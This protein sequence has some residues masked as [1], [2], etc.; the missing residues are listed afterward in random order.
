MTN[1]NYFFFKRKLN[2]AISE[3]ASDY[4]TFNDFKRGINN[5]KNNTFFVYSQVDSKSIP[6]ICMNGTDGAK[7]YMNIMFYG[8]GIYTTLSYE[9]CA[10][11]DWSN[12]MVKYAVKK[13]AFNNFLIF[14]IGIKKLLQTKGVLTLH[15]KISDTVKRLFSHDD[16]KMFE[17]YYGKGL[18]ELDK[19]VVSCK[20]SIDSW[21]VEKEFL[22]VA[23]EGEGDISLRPGYK[24][25]SEKRLDVSNVDGFI[26][27]SYFG[28]TAIFR[29][30]DILM[31]Y[32]YCIKTDY[33]WPIDDTDFKYCM[34]SEEN[35]NNSNYVV[36]AFRRSRKNYP[37]TEFTEKTSCGFSLVKNGNKFN[38]LNSRTNKYLSPM[39]F[40]YCSSFDP[41]SCT[42]TCGINTDEGIIEFNL[43]SV[44]YGKDLKIKFRERDNEERTDW[45][46]ISYQDF[47]SIMEEF[48][49]NS[50]NESVSEV[51]THKNYDQFRKSIK[52][53]KNV[54]IYRSTDPKTAKIEFENGSN[55]EFSGTS[56]DASLYYGLGVYCVRDT[57]SLFC[58]KYGMGVV[59]FMLKDGFKDFVI[60]DNDLRSKVDPGKSVYDEI[61]KLVPQDVIKDINDGLR[62]N[63]RI[64][65]S[66]KDDLRTNGINAFKNMKSINDYH[67]TLG[68]ISNTAKY[69]KAFIMTLLG[70]SIN[71]P[72]APAVRDERL[73][74]KT[75]IRGI[76]FTGA[77]DGHVVVVR[78]F[79]SLMPVDY[80]VDGGRTW[81]VENDNGKFTKD[82]FDKIN[83]NVD[84][85]YLYR[86][87]Y[88]DVSFR[89]HPTGD[90]SLV[91][92][93]QGYNWKD[94]WFHRSLLPIDVDL[95]TNFD[96]FS[97][98]AEFKLAGYEFAIMVDKDLNSRLSFKNDETGGWEECPYD[99]FIEFIGEAQKM[100]LIDNNK[101]VNQNCLLNPSTR[102]NK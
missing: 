101:K 42:A 12:A 83:T 1:N 50:L 77:A 11:Y 31:P 86:G 76:V 35:F 93:K 4:E 72:V 87:E 85:Y 80:S 69:A 84:P 96:P 66:I 94:I 70:H 82:N 95:A 44:N 81:E 68:N 5:P 30:T 46:N 3:I 98:K 51:F 55:R 22:N 16:V 59:K 78:D 89:A 47:Y 58:S 9:S 57:I 36:D 100:G 92:G 10:S 53:S 61:I 60:F 54:F 29:T 34:N 79:N 48:K 7:E 88:G 97:G 45:E 99:E 38:L 6:N 43:T 71:D 20:N 26:Y 19:K 18:I 2:E 56:G 49:D 37:D 32:S 41:I 64:F 33:K 90:F 74:S 67:R 52:D 21:R 8:R 23:R 27:Y 63:D 75:R 14:D 17:S 40:D 15:E 25:A 28:P 62:N 102:K 13:G 39:D 73:L 91:N 24:Y 65:Y